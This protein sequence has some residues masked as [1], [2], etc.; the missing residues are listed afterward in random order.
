MSVPCIQPSFSTQVNKSS[1]Q[2]FS[3]SFAPSIRGISTVSVQPFTAIL[4]LIA[5]TEI[6]TRCLPIFSQSSFKN[7]SLRTD[8]PA[9]GFGFQAALPTITFSAPRE[10][11]SRAFFTSRIPPPTRTF[12][13]L[14][15][16]LSR[17]VF[18]VLPF[19]SVLR[20]AW[21]RSMIATSP[22]LSKSEIKE[23]ASSRFK[24]KSFPFLSWTTEPSFMSI[25]AITI[26]AIIA[27]KGLMYK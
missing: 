13:R 2:Y 18:F 23:S 1:E 26:N 9:F 4:P 6:M 24:T 11:N 7:S 25:E 20:S 8:S 17:A 22:Y 12:P 3:A 21:S 5:S 16:D 27:K 19:S 15:K 14:S 10:I